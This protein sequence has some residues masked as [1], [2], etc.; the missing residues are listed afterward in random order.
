MLLSEKI[1]KHKKQNRNDNHNRNCYNHSSFYEIIFIFNWI[2]LSSRIHNGYTTPFRSDLSLR[3]AM[4]NLRMQFFICHLAN[5]DTSAQLA[6]RKIICWNCQ[7]T[8]TISCYSKL[9]F[10][11]TSLLYKILKSLYTFLKSHANLLLYL[12]H[13]WY[14]RWYTIY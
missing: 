7:S 6:V 3:K 5:C 13:F 8:L 10:T 11:L 9:F 12:V 1:I 14:I 2:K 4:K